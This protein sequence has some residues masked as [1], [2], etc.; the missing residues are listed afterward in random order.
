MA[1]QIGVPELT[2]QLGGTKLV[3]LSW[4]SNYGTTN[5]C[6][7]VG[8]STM[9]HQLGAPELTIQLWHYKLV[10]LSWLFNYA[11]P[12]WCPFFFFLTPPLIVY[13]LTDLTNINWKQVKV[14]YPT[15]AHQ[16]GAPELAV[17]LWRTNLVCHSW[18]SKYGAPNWCAIVDCPN[19]VHQTVQL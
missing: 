16:I 14:D 8:C 5:W 2:I 1:L 6:A 7:C 19:M 15:M 3:S 11:A 9:A 10:C 13:Y 12:N 17:Q 18:L 4:L